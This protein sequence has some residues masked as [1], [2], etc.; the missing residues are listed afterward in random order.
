MAAWDLSIEDDNVEY[1][2]HDAERARFTLTVPSE[3][4]RVF[5]YRLRK[6]H[7]MRSEHWTESNDRNMEDDTLG[8][9]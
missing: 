9:D 6:Y 1:K 5:Y 7:G 2:K 8:V 4:K 3:S